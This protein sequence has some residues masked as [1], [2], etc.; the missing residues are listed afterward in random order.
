[1]V[2]KMKN[3]VK[4]DGWMIA[5]VYCIIINDCILLARILVL[6]NCRY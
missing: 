3:A 4:V 6:S 1:M 5:G 2:M